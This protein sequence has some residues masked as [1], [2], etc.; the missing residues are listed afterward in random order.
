MTLALLLDIQ[1]AE[2][3]RLSDE[4]AARMITALEDGRRLL[5]EGLASVGDDSPTERAQRLRV[6]LVQAE[7]ALLSLRDRLGL[8]LSEFERNAHQMTIEHL[9]GLVSFHGEQFPGARGLD[10]HIVERLS[11][12]GQLGLHR[13]A[14]HRYS[15]QALDAIQRELVAGVAANIGQ[16][17]IAQRI[18]GIDS[19]L[20]KDLKPKAELIARMELSRAYNDSQLEAIQLWAEEDPTHREDPIL[21]RIEE[22]LD[23][24]N[25]PF[26][27][28]SDGLTADPNANFRVPVS[29]VEAEARKL[30]KSGKGVLWPVVAGAYVGASL[31]AHYNDRGRIVA[32]RASWSE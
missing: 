24:R 6:S 18:A 1:G 11:R 32:W 28:V 27:R 2:L 23:A 22:Y 16:A 4:A 17:K 29:A 7:T 3:A 31:P 5:L 20:F 25:H 26:S 21:K 8:V 13:Y 30:K 19:D 15:A 14:T 9:L 10:L 12:K